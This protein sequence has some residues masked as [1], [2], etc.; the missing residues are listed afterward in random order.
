MPSPFFIPLNALRAIEIVARRGAL[1]PAAEELGVT[2]GAVSQHIRR[3]EERL[4]IQLFERTPRGL[5]PTPELV[6]Q[7]PRLTEGFD[8]LATGLAG[9]R[10]DAETS[11][12]ITVGSMFASLWLVP[13]LGRFAALHPDIE[14]RLVATSKFLDLGR[15]DIDCGVRFGL[16]HWPGVEASLFGR[17]DYSPFCAPEL[18][19][20][21]STP[22][23][24]ARV[25]VIRDE[26]TLLN[27]DTWLAAAGV[28]EA[29]TMAGP[30]YTDPLLAYE[31]ALAGQGVL[32]VMD[33]L[34]V[35]A[36]AT[37]RLVRPFPVGVESEYAHW[38]VSAAG[39]R[40]RK[41]ARLFRDWLE[42]EMAACL[43]ITGRR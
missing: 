18:A 34:M 26:S 8:H 29:P 39:R 14:L 21:L 6:D 13:R 2:P 23:D 35:D 24:L 32:L 43:P 33:M 37:G 12:T 22:A 5:V 4:G 20:R 7:L 31:A 36:L 16:G 17:R 9:L 41:P 42:A 19:A 1:S 25:Q 38:F 15:Q 28:A 3:A 30:S 27:W 11:L 10:P 40:L